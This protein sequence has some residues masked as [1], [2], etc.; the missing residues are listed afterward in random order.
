METWEE[1]VS[2]AIRLTDGGPW[3]DSLYSIRVESIPA[4][5]NGQFLFRSWTRQGKNPNG[6]W[7]V[8]QKRAQVSAP[9]MKSMRA[10]PLSGHDDQSADSVLSP[11]YQTPILASLWAAVCDGETSWLVRTIMEA[12]EADLPEDLV[13]AT[14]ARAWEACEA[15]RTIPKYPGA[16]ALGR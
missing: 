13:R 7:V 2:L 9:F 10:Q 6:D 12:W 16:A 8:G 5:N 11:T 4:L 14:V 1:A 3:A 15:S